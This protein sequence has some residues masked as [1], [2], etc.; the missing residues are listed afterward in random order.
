MR[1]N[2][3]DRHCEEEGFAKN[4]N[5]SAGYTSV[6]PS[7][8]FDIQRQRAGA[9]PADK[10]NSLR[11]SF[12]NERAGSAGKSEAIENKAFKDKER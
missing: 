12:D 5:G 1:K 4:R 9:P 3:F 11:S 10:G 2:N 7:K 6:S 8:T